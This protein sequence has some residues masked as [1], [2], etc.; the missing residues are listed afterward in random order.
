MKKILLSLAVLAFSCVS[1]FAE[2]VTD[3]LTWDKIVE[4]GKSTSYHDFS[5]KSITSSAKYAG[6][7]SS[8]ADSYIQLRTTNNNAGIVTTTSG[9]KLKS[10][11][12]T[13][14]AK[15]TDRSIE[16]YGKNEAYAAATDLYGDA[17]GTLLK[18]IA[19]ND[20]SKTLTVEGDYTFVGLKS[21]NGAIYVDKIE[22]T[23]ETEASTKKNVVVE[24]AGKTSYDVFV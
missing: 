11:T 14:N 17:K 20:D 4:A 7:A 3:E 24:F 8:G 22:I 15:T 12:I 21:A 16:I 9:G 6:N 18:S 13:F 5:D 23:W 2:D 1:A 19:A 10:V